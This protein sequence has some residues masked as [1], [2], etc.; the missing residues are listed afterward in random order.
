MSIEGRSAPMVAMV[1][2]SA[3]IQPTRS[4]PQNDFDIEPIV[5][6]RSRRAVM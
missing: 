1:A 6:T 4:P 2:R 5:R 3:R